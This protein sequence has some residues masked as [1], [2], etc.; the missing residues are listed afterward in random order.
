MNLRFLHLIS[1][2][3]CFVVRFSLESSINVEKC[4]LIIS[5]Q[6]ISLDTFCSILSL[7]QGCVDHK[8]FD[9]S[10]TDLE[11][12][13]R[14]RRGNVRC[15]LLR[16]QIKILSQPKT[17]P[18]LH[19]RPKDLT[20]KLE[21][22]KETLLKIAFHA[23]FSD[24]KMSFEH[25][26]EKMGLEYDSMYGHLLPPISAIRDILQNYTGFP[27]AEKILE[28]FKRKL[29]S[30]SRTSESIVIDAMEELTAYLK[31]KILKS[32]GK[33]D[34]LNDTLK[35]RKETSSEDSS[36]STRKTNEELQN[37][38]K[39]RRPPTP[40]V[41]E[42]QIKE[43]VST[44]EPHPAPLKNSGASEKANEEFEKIRNLFSGKS[45]ASDDAAKPK[46]SCT[47]EKADE[48]FKKIRN[49][50]SGKSLITSDDAAKPKSSGTSGKA[51][52]EF[53]KFETYSVASLLLL[54][55]MLRS[56]KV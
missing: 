38:F 4:E 16:Q 31:R 51:E 11:T 32:R 24:E 46:S 9:A 23:L 52:E 20:E 27:R 13:L 30:T 48:E 45:L 19:L 2:I 3:L 10:R 49:L 7:E 44:I 22:L 53:K 33:S 41:N 40:L 55:M 42:R 12:V 26:I 15:F 43:S 6:P 36:P 1:C 17:N 56:L 25:L 54:L 50:F 14:Y 5:D 39:A 8:F 21:D 37:I 29:A 28:V 47:S 35:I 18:N 34:I